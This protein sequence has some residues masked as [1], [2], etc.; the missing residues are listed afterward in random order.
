MLVIDSE[1]DRYVDDH[2]HEEPEL[3]RELARATHLKM[4]RP[5]MLSGNLQ[6]QFLKMLCKMIHAQHILEIGTYTGYAAISMAMGMDPQGELH[7]IDINDEIEEFTS[8]FI[9]RSG[10]SDRIHF[11][12]GDASDVITQLDGPFDLVFIDA[13]KR[14]YSEYY[15]LVFDKVRSG[16]IIIA[17]D[18]LWDGNVLNK[19]TKDAQTLGILAYNDKVQKDERVENVLLPIRHGLMVVR[20]I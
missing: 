4:L 20:K 17:D 9:A 12:I 6:G 16:G 19:E 1:L 5:R 8:D 13:D 10:F 3:L 2:T 15:D 18:A 7:T 14:K 11:H